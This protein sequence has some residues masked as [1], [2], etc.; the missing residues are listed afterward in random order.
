MRAVGDFTIDDFTTVI[1]PDV[2]AIVERHDKLRLV[3]A[4]G[5]RFTGFGEGAWGEVTAGSATSTST[6]V[7]W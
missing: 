2:D 4:L 3:L 6:E 5:E 1:E 7:P